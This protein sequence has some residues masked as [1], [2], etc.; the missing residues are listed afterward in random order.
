MSTHVTQ[1]VVCNA[2][3]YCCNDTHALGCGSSGCGGYGSVPDT[4]IIEFCSEKC[5]HELDKRMKE[6]WINYQEVI[7]GD[8]W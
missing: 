2:N 6:A 7:N 8:G 5:F 1:C 4:P 3:C